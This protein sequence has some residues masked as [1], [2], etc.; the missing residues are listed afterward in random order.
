MRYMRYICMLTVF[1][2]IAFV[3]AGSARGNSPRPDNDKRPSHTCK[4]DYDWDASRE[5]CEPPHCKKKDYNWDDSRESCEPP[6]CK[7]H[8]GWDDSRGECRN[9]DKDGHWDNEGG[10]WDNKDGHWDGK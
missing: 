7:Q 8:Q 10:H 5:S 4:K 1:T 3:G 9:E 6:S 2:A